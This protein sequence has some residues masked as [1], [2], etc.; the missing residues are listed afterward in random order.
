MF[1]LLPKLVNELQ[2]SD[3]TCYEDCCP[4]QCVLIFWIFIYDETPFTVVDICEIHIYETTRRHIS[5]AN[6]SEIP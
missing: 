6:N 5:E 1:F 3:D 4:L 2:I